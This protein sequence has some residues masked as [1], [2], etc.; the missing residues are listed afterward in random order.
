MENKIEIEFDLLAWSKMLHLIMSQSGEVGW[1][2]LSRR[3]DKNYYQIYDVIIYPQTVTG[4]TVNT[5][6]Q[7]YAK[8]MDKLSD[9]D[10]Y[11]LRTHC[12]SHVNFGVTPSSTDIKDR[13]ELFSHL[14]K[15][16]YQI[17]MIWNKHLDYDIQIVDNKYKTNAS[18]KDIEIKI[19]GYDFYEY[20]NPSLV[21]QKFNY[22]TKEKI[23]DELSEIIRLF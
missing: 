20:Q 10:F 11:N 8:W 15:E 5:D 16:N 14:G 22:I 4:A 13:E 19:D 18:T 23:E 21:K 7:E 12:H 17:V 1:H 3:I 9:D 6:Q 2:C